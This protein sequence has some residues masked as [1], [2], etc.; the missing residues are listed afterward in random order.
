VPDAATLAF[1]VVKVSAVLLPP[2]QAASSKTN[3]TNT[4]PKMTFMF[5]F[6]L[7]RGGGIQSSKVALVN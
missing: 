2:P 3:P 7:C 5:V 4:V 6:P 1:V